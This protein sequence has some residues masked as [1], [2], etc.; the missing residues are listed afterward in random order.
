[1]LLILADAK[2]GAIQYQKLEAGGLLNAFLVV[3]II[4]LRMMRKTSYC[5]AGP[6]T[7]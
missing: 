3:L 6:R 7:S 2:G 4:S 1:V 5:D